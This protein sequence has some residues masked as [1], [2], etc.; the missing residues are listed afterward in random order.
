VRLTLLLRA[1]HGEQV[2]QLAFKWEVKRRYSE[3]FH[4]H[5]LLSLEWAMLP[6]LPPKLLFS[7][8]CDDVAE[9]MMALDNYLRAL[10]ASPALA[11]SPLVCTFLDAIDVQSFR[12]QMIPRMQQMEAEPGS[13]DGPIP[14]QD[15]ALDQPY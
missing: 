2:R 4:F 15:E 7:Q 10:L 9:R 14:M 5:E 13:A 6:E 12:G 11:L 8:D 1:V 3:F